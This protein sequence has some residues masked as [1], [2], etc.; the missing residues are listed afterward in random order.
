MSVPE[1]LPAPEAS[2]VRVRRLIQA[3]ARRIQSRR[4]ASLNPSSQ[5]ASR[6][7]TPAIPD[8]PNPSGA[9]RA[10]ENRT[11]PTSPPSPAQS[12]PSTLLHRLVAGCP[13]PPRHR[14]VRV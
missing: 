10:A 7:N 3:L 6:P 12:A 8:T 1:T 2:Q 9:P 11:P 14:K 13:R 4:L 5:C